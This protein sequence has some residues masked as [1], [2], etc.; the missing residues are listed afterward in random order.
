MLR[1]SFRPPDRFSMNGC[2]PAIPAYLSAAPAGRPSGHHSNL[3]RISR[4]T[5]R[6]KPPLRTLR[7][8]PPA[9]PEAEYCILTPASIRGKQS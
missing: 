1:P 3:I 5:K 4:A 6:Q 7:L 8:A 2:F 9:S